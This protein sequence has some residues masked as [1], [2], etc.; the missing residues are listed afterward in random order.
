MERTFDE[1][2]AEAEAAPTEGW[3][4]S[5][6]DG[7]ATEERPTWGYQRLLGARLAR[8]SAALDIETGGGEV[9]AGAGGDRSHHGR[10]GI[11]ATQ[12]REGHRDAAP[13]RRGGGARV[14][15]AATTVRGQRFRSG[16]QSPPQRRL[17][18]GHRPCARP[19]RHLSGPTRGAGERLRTRRV[20]PR[21]AARGART[22][23]SG[24]GRGR[25]AR[26]RT[27]GRGSAVR[28]ATHG[29]SSTSARRSISCA[30]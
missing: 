11:V 5:W 27:R 9:L 30:R 25:G 18:A 26:R 29:V 13:A 3:E 28:A 7:R 17:V 23:T 2:V 6:L 19:R 16:Q 21:S 22:A 24:H 8:A 10:D 12:P 14:G 20:L 4:F 15:R 1:L